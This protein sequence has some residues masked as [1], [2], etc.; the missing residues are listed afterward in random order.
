MDRKSPEWD[1]RVRYQSQYWLL[2]FCRNVFAREKCH[3]S[4]C[5]RE[6]KTT[7]PVFDWSGL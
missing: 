1:D 2:L 7:G 4:Y 5:N 3:C 6:I